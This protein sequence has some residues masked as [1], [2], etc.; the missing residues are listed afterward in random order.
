MLA[1]QCRDDEQLAELD[2]RL[3]MADSPQDEALQALREHQEAAGMTFDS[4]D[5]PV[6]APDRGDL[7]GWMT[8]N[9]E[10]R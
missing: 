8:A 5:A 9:E 4:P 6:A 10:F 2:S 1:D 7:P 3:G